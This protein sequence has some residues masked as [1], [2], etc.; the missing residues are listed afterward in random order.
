MKILVAV[1]R[2]GALDADAAVTV[3]QR[4]VDEDYLDFV[5]GSCDTA[6]LGLSLRLRDEMGTGEVVVVTAGPRDAEAV[7]L[8]CLAMGADR[9]VR[10]AHEE[11]Q[12]HDPLTVARLLAIAVESERPDLVLCGAASEDADQTVTGTALAALVDLPNATHVTRANCDPLTRAIIVTC[13]LDGGPVDTV[14]LQPPAMLSVEAGTAEAPAITMR[15]LLAAARQV[16][17]VLS[18]DPTRTAVQP[19]YMIRSLRVAQPASTQFLIGNARQ[20]ASQIL[21]LVRGETL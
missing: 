5:L 6:A 15:S 20:V 4:H 9:A 21:D 11:G 17:P 12:L 7:L 8:N 2:S 10:V 1:K 18:P 16:V 14:E 19:G 3:D 13:V